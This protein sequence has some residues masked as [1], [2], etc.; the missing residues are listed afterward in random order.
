MICFRLL[1]FSVSRSKTVQ[2]HRLLF[3]LKST[4]VDRQ[5]RFIT[6]VGSLP[7]GPRMIVSHRISGSRCWDALIP[8]CPLCS[9]TGVELVTGGPRQGHLREEWAAGEILPRGEGQGRSSEGAEPGLQGHRDGPGGEGRSTQGE[10]RGHHSKGSAA[11]R[12]LSSQTGNK[13]S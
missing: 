8:L 11:P 13:R 6:S 5:K 2:L 4:L 1:H 9:V 10:N 12:V 7:T 3:F